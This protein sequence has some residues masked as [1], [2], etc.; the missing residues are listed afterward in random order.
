MRGERSKKR[1]KRERKKG[2]IMN[3]WRNLTRLKKKMMRE[4]EERE[5]R[6]NFRAESE[7]KNLL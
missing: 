1:K 6:D 7:R 3:A 5:K 4:R 2:C